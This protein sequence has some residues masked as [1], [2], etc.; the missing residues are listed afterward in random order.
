MFVFAEKNINEIVK[1]FDADFYS[2]EQQLLKTQLPDGAVYELLEC[3][4]CSRAVRIYLYSS[5]GRTEYTCMQF[6][7]DDTWYFMKK[8]VFYDEPYNAIDA[9]EL[10][11]YFKYTDKCYK[12][13]D[14]SFIEDIDFSSS[15]AVVDFRN[16]KS[17]VKLIENDIY[18][19]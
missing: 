7:E 14:N 3:E 17:L 1:I 19:K 2:S 15:P 6:K 11:S 13:L 4:L 10:I 16:A 5:L 8:S 18:T 9:E 12:L